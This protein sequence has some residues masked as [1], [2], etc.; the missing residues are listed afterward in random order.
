L[1]RGAVDELLARI[2]PW[3]CILCGAAAA[4]ID[5]CLPCLNRLPWL[6]LPADGGAHSVVTAALLYESP[7]D[8]LITG[9]KF[10]GRLAAARVLGELLAIRVGEAGQFG[11][12]QPDTLVPVPLH[13]WR[14]LRRGYN[15]AALIANTAGR[16]LGI[17]VRPR[18][19]RRCRKTLP[20]MQLGR[21]ERL[22]GPAGAFRVPDRYRHAC[23]GAH[24]ALVDDVMTTGATLAACAAALRDAGADRVECWAVA[25]VR[26]G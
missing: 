5:L 9:L 24:V 22:A 14:L 2:A 11:A 19:L 7:V 16:T 4:G 20:Q 10:H 15:Q 13:R 25:R 17:P 6:P 18:W 1:P 26:P 3:R 21:R 12:S 8:E 23:A